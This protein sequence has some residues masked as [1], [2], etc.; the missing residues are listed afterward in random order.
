ME[1]RALGDTGHESSLLAFGAIV[2]E[3]PFVSQ[4]EA[5]AI[6]D[7]V[8]DRG[9]NHI[10]VGPAYGDAEV[11]LGPRLSARREEVF[12]A[13][14]TKRRTRDGVREEL[15]RSLDRMGVDHIDLYQLHDVTTRTEIDEALGAGG[16]MEAILDAREAG[17]IDHIGITSHADPG[18]LEYALRQFDFE[19]VMFPMNFTIAARDDPAES[20]ERVL[21][22]ADDRG[23]GTIGIKAFAKG[24]WPAHL[25]DRPETDRPYA[26]WYEPYDDPE[27][28]DD[29]LRF[30]LSQGMDTVT[31]AGDPRLLEPILDA[32][33]GFR[34][35]TPD[36]VRALREVGRDRASPVPTDDPS[37]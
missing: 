16:A 21:E 7:T 20:Y 27:A 12:L 23:T 34:S 33:E 10:D 32:A 15:E 22:L 25:R 2:L 31:N 5:N 19:T 9:V 13:C 24:P 8:L 6:V 11:K 35:L 14:K 29:C 30:A 4:Q 28:I 17:V 1:T 36:E 37:G 18:V 26:T 3:K